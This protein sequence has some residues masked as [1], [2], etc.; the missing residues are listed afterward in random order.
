MIHPDKIGVEAK[1]K[2]DELL[3]C[4]RVDMATI[5]IRTI[6]AL[7]ITVCRIRTYCPVLVPY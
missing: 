4:H 5:A 7:Y 3:R 2:E 6:A 1:K